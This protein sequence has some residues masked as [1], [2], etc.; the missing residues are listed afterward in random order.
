[1]I[2]CYVLGM[3]LQVLTKKIATLEQRL[4]ALEGQKPRYIDPH[5]GLRQ[6]QGLWKKKPR[7][8]ADL[9]AVRKK[10]WP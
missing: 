7:T 4:N 2:I 9:K 10:L 5:I 1:M 3:T 8:K 6:L